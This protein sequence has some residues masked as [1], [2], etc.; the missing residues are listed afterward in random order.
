MGGAN[1]TPANAY[2]GGSLGSSGSGSWITFT[3]GT[4]NN[5]N[6]LTLQSGGADTHQ[7]PGSTTNV[8]FIADTGSNVNTNIGANTTIESLTFTGTDA[9]ITTGSSITISGTIA[10]S[11]TNQTLT[12]NAAGV[13]GNTAGNGI[14]TGIGS[15]T[16]IINANLALGGNQTWTLNASPSS[17]LIVTGTVSG[18]H[19]L[20]IGGTGEVILQG[21]NTF[22]NG[23]TIS[24]SAI[25]VLSNT[26]A[27]N[28]ASPDA[29]SFGAGSA[30]TLDI[31]GRN[32][33]IGTLSTNASP[34]S[35]VIQNANVSTSGTLTVSQSGSSTYAGVLADGAGSAALALNL[36]SGTLTL[37]GVNTYTGPTNV[38]GGILNIRGSL[39]AGSLVSVNGGILSGIGGTINGAVTVKN[40]AEIMPGT[41]A[42]QGTL[43]LGNGLTINSGGITA[44][45]IGTGTSDFINITGGSLVYNSGAIIEVTGGIAASGTFTILTATSAPSLTGVSLED[46]NGNS[47]ATNDPHYSITINGNSIILSITP[48]NTAIPNITITAP[49]NGTRVM[50]NSSNISVS[51][52]VGNTGVLTLNGTL[53]GGGGALT[54]GNF[55]PT[56]GTFQTGTGAVTIF[57]GTIANTGTALGLNS[58]KVTVTDGSAQPTSATATGTL[59]ILG[60][61]VVAATAGL[62]GSIHEGATGTAL[63]TLSSTAPDN[64]FTR[65]T[66]GDGGVDSGPYGISVTGGNP[67]GTFNG[68]FFDGRTLTGSFGA[69]GSQSGTV[70]LT[71]TGEGLAGESPVNV[72]VAYSAQ[73]FSGQ[74]SWASSTGGSW[75]SNNNWGDTQA[76]DLNGPALPA[77][78]ACSASATRP[79]LTML[80]DSPELPQ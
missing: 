34:G 65:V 52:S 27:L 10:G 49:A 56:S 47:L 25:V 58:F 18:A 3:G 53:S 4:S 15:G 11:G 59:D 55:S 33:T 54:V 23:L 28:G 43:T 45:N 8:F 39:G 46:M 62:F 60:N 61:R 9:T 80:R 77:W 2:W 13:S 31:N 37:A 76:P 50:A 30:G 19:S 16:D 68:S 12:I 29:V 74:A 20:T 75:V 79:R 21:N 14:T 51:G 36:A 1:P 64:Q 5:S 57:G 70:T 48:A 42:S 32:V 73:V 35:P 67:G 26:G 7:T 69:L 38:N 63:T 78:P 17:P 22:T 44:F 71:T 66:V 24:G 41:A 72:G 6:W 40:G